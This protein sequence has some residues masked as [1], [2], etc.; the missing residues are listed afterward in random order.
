ML[1]TRRFRYKMSYFESSVRV[2]LLISYPQKYTPHRVTKNVSTLDILPTMVD[3]IGSKLDP[4]LPMDGKSLLP[5]LEG[6]DSNEANDTVIAEYTGEGTV[7]PL[8]M[9][10]RG[11]WKFVICPADGVQLFDLA[12]DPLE[13]RDLAKILSGAQSVEPPLETEYKEKAAALLASFEAEAKE[14]WDFESITAEVRLSQRKRRFVWNAFEAKGS[15]REKWDFDPV[16]DGREK[17]VTSKPRYVTSY[18]SPIPLP[19]SSP[20]CFFSLFS[21]MI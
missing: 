6:H 2:P 9:I 11:T 1:L 21:K 10:K 8:M 3:L 12:N 14:R 5:F 7:S 20:P 4:E 15:A 13:L 19:P 18:T 16:K 17:S